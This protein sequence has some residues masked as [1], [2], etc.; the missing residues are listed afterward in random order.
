[1][2]NDY[3]NR[4]WRYWKSLPREAHALVPN[5]N[6]LSL[7]G[8]ATLAPKVTITEYLGPR[9]LVFRLAGT[10]VDD[11]RGENQ[12]GINVFDQCEPESVPFFEQLWALY[13]SHPAGL[14]HHYQYHSQRASHIVYSGLHLP[15]CDEEG[16]ICYKI[17]LFTQTGDTLGEDA[18][19]PG[20]YDNR[21]M[22]DIQ[23][24][25]VGAGIPEFNPD[26]SLT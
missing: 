5:R 23:W 24:I 22:R 16:T 10:E 12:T 21:Q 3:Q 13:F 14:S 19:T 26:K 7:P 1:M 4:F 6:S 20:W 2:F 9:R 17:A 25:D 8:L 18:S 15:L 11:Q